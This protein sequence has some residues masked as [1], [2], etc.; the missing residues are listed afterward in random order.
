[1]ESRSQHPID[2]LVRHALRVSFTHLEASVKEG[3]TA[4]A[5]VTT[6]S[7]AALAERAFRREGL[8]IASA[9]LV[10][11]ASLLALKARR[12]AVTDSGT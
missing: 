12:V 6:A 8:A 1:M 9:C 2:S 10:V 11:F 5:T 3:R 4:A 7:E